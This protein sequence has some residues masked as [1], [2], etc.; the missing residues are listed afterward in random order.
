MIKQHLFCFCLKLKWKPIHIPNF[1][2]V[3]HFNYNIYAFNTFHTGLRCVA[4]IAT[5]EKATGLLNSFLEEGRAGEVGLVVVDEAHMLGDQGGRGALLEATI[6]KLRHSASEFG[7]NAAQQCTKFI[8][9][10]ALPFVCWQLRDQWI[11]HGHVWNCNHLL[12][13]NLLV[14][15]RETCELDMMFGGIVTICYS[16]PF[17]CW[18]LRDQWVGHGRVQNCYHL[19]LCN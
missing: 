13:C 4:Y 7:T 14:G 8:P 2:S 12:L 10:V 18:W 16:A 17:V 6:T 9:F 11:V 3:G 5:I 19:L 1:F 15:D